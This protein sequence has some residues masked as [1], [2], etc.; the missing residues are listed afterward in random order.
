MVHPHPVADPRRALLLH[1]CIL[2]VTAAAK[3]LQVVA[4]AQLQGSDLTPMSLRAL[5]AS[6]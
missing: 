5:I 1:H 3:A 2:V 4:L 6:A